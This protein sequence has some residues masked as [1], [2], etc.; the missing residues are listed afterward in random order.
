MGIA[1][2]QENGYLC[3]RQIVEI[4]KSIIIAAHAMKGIATSTITNT[5]TITTTKKAGRAK[6]SSASWQRQSF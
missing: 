6:R 5:N 1:G 3:C 2:K 4:W